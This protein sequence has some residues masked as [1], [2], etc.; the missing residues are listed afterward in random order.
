M[1][2]KEPDDV[3]FYLNDNI[4]Q[5]AIDLLFENGYKGEDIVDIFRKSSI[6]I[7]SD[8]IEKLLDLKEGTL[9]TGEDL[10]GKMK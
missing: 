10:S 8:E 1:E 2:K 4:F 6:T 3:P 7:F 5:G 9:F